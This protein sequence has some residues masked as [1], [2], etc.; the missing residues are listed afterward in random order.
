MFPDSMA[1]LAG[2]GH[3]VIF[4]GSV[5]EPSNEGVIGLI[6][7]RISIGTVFPNIMGAI[8]LM[9]AVT[10]SETGS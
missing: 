5:K 7:H 4:Y 2:P 1:I 10:A 3:R 8:G 6:V 9:E